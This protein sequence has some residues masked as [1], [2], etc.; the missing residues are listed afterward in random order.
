MSASAHSTVVSIYKDMKTT[1]TSHFIARFAG[2][3]AVEVLSRDLLN[4]HVKLAHAKRKTDNGRRGAAASGNLLNTLDAAQAPQGSVDSIPA[5]SAPDRQHGTNDVLSYP[6]ELENTSGG[7]GFLGLEDNTESFGFNYLDNV[8]LPPYY[9]Q[10]AFY[11]DSNIEPLMPPDDARQLNSQMEVTAEQQPGNHSQGGEESVV[12]KPPVERNNVFTAHFARVSQEDWQWLSVQVSNYSHVLPSNYELPSRHAISRYLFGFLTGFHPHFPII[13]P[14]TLSFKQMAPELILALAAVGSNY[15]LESHQAVKI[16]PI[17]RL[18]AMEKFNYGENYNESSSP[19]ST[20]PRASHQSSNK[21]YDM[22]ALS[23]N[24]T[25]PANGIQNNREPQEQLET[26]QALFFLMAMGTWGGEH[27]SLVRQ[28][29][30]TQSILA[31]LVRQ[32][33]LSESSHMPVTWQDWARAE[34]ARR[35][36]LVIY[37]FFNLH[38]IAFNNPSPMLITDIHLN[39]PCAEC[40]W[41]ALDPVRWKAINEKSARAPRFQDCFTGLLRPSASAPIHSSLGGHVLISALLQRIISIQ[42]SIRLEGIESEIPDE[43]FLSLRRALQK[44]QSGWEQNPESS[45]SPLDKHGPIAFNSRALYHL[46]HVRLAM[47]IGPARSILEPSPIEIAQR[48]YDAPRLHRSPRLLLAA[49]H[50]AAA[51]C[52]PVQMGV[53]FVGRAPSWSVMHAVCSIEYAY[54][55]NQFLETATCTNLEIPL[56]EDDRVLLANIKET[57]VEVET[58]MPGGSPKLIETHPRLLGA[59]AVRAWAMIL[60]GMRNWNAVC[61]ITKTL[62]IY[63]DLLEHNHG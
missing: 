37:C 47:D 16:F 45:Y 3:L 28:G 41:G 40:E 54:T 9:S 18:I 52:S 57:L 4:R 24:E 1:I 60:D 31:I 42:Q 63:A 6:S 46:A 29:L 55:L 2:T 26:M 62:F 58:S 22:Q 36:K 7:L 5:L 44:W 12:P 50:A 61:L 8:Y 48:L 23:R 49:K 21:A 34:S 53:Y 35:T 51:L 33:G 14:P 19:N 20:S 30:A 11:P 25:R 56:E 15:C 39:I 10:L 17:A 27:R 32:H 13:H 59:K 43:Q 38:T